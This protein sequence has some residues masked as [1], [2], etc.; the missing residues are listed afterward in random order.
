[1]KA[2]TIGFTGF[3]AGQLGGLVDIQLHVPSHCIEQVED[4]HLLFEHLITK[5][6]RERTY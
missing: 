3:D 2:T 4:I 1:V 6:L 5:V